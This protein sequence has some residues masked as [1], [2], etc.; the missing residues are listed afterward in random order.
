[1][2]NWP[3][4]YWHVL[5]RPLNQLKILVRYSVGVD[6]AIHIRLKFYSNLPSG[7]HVI[8]IRICQEMESS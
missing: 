2:I 3:N 5:V 1:M 4:F 8:D 7:C 6:E